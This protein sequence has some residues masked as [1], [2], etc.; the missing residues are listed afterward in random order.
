MNHKVNRRIDDLVS[1]LLTIEEDLFYERKFKEV[2]MDSMDASSKLEGNERHARGV[3][4]PDSAVKVHMDKHHV[5][6][7]YI[8]V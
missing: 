2:M 8:H 3:E 6:L 1:T 4:I 5:A 7:V